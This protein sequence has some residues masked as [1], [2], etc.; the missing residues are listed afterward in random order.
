M[1]KIDIFNE[2][3]E[4][5]VNHILR[6]IFIEEVS[7]GELVGICAKLLQFSVIHSSISKEEALHAITILW[8][9]EK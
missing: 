8:E 1:E 9:E 2:H 5:A 7:P 4:N 6:F 3:V